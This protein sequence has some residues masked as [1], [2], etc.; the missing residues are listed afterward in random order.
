MQVSSA[1]RIAFEVL[2]RVEAERAFA[3]EVLHAR[4]GEK[5]SRPDA[6]LATELTLGVLRW[7]RL[8]DFLIQK[9]LAKPAES[10]D[11]EVLLA[12]RLGL[13]QLR[14]LSRVPA[15]AAV[16][17]SV[18]LVKRARKRSAAGLVN[19][20]LRKAASLSVAPADKMEPL[21][22][23]GLGLADRLGVLYSHPTWMVERWLTQFGE[24]RTT[25]LLA[26][27]NRAPRTTCAVHDPSQRDQIAVALRKE[28]FEV[29]PGAL[30]RSAVTLRGGNPA[31]TEAFRV[32]AI[33][34]QDEASQLVAS[35]VDVVS[36]QSVLDLCAAPG[37][38]TAILA[39]AAG[40]QALVVA[41]DRHAHRLR[42]TAEHLRRVGAS[43]VHLVAL[44][45]LHPLPLEMCFDRILVDAPC[46]GTGT[47]A[48]NPEI[49][50]RLRQDDLSDL[51]RRQVTLL[52]HALDKLAPS[53]RLVYS[54][55]SLEPEENE[56]VV[57]GVLAS[58]RDAIRQTAGVDAL[59]PHLATGVTADS[60]FDAD[61][62]FR[63]FP[64]E[65]HSDGFFAAVLTK[66]VF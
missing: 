33:S 51:H 6:A 23:P 13:Y 30:L 62:Q 47:L 38:K 3:A 57:A 14:F 11:L 53:G 21:L 42:I 26:A 16:N 58:R 34:I 66:T 22:P 37:G 43:H 44:D 25:A 19:A 64:P 54:T 24:A 20:V 48:R 50:W 32:G 4:L 49:R 55:C 9:F 10:L 61:G 18:E 39:R 59:A 41:A 46:S 35:L 52:S 17:E 60:L 56:Q 5:V 12:L 28:G 45:A 2:R 63:T 40:P 8:L 29:Q 1:R 36:G 65:H 31:N 15:S 7:Q 27:N